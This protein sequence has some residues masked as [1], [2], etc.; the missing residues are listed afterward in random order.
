MTLAWKSMIGWRAGAGLAVV[1]ILLAKSLHPIVV[2][3]RRRSNR[4]RSGTL[5]IL[6]DGDD[7]EFE[8]VG[9]AHS[10]C[11]SGLLCHSIIAVHGLG[12]DPDRTWTHAVERTQ[13]RED[14][15]QQPSHRPGRIHLLQDLLR[16][17]FPKA[18]IL[19]FK[20]N[21]NWLM[22]APLKTIEEIG[23]SLLE[24]IK[25][26][27]RPRVV[28]RDSAVVHAD[29]NKEYGF[30]TDH[31]GLNKCAGREDKL[32]T[33]L[34]TAIDSL[35]APSLLQQ[36]DTLIC[37]KHYTLERLKIERLSEDLLSM[38]QCYINLAVVEQFG[39]DANRSMNGGPAAS[40]FSLFARQKVETP[41]RT[42][43]FDLATIFNPRKRRDGCMIE[44]RRILIRGRAGVG[45]TTLCKKMVYDFTHG[46]Q[47]ELHRSW[48]ER[49]SRLLWVPLRSLKGWSPTTYNY[50]NLFYD[51]Y[52][53]EEGDEYGLSL[54]RELARALNDPQSGT[55]LFILDGLD[56]I[57][58]ELGGD[59]KMA[60]FLK[61]LFDQPNVIITSRPSAKLP[62]GLQDLD[63]ELETI[64]FYPDQVKGYIK[65]TFTDAKTGEVDHR[66]I[67]KV[68]SFLE[69][70]WLIQGLVRIPI[71]LDALCYTWEDFNP[72]TVP[73]TMTGIYKA[74]V[75][76][77]WVKDVLRLE[78]KDH[79]G[80][81]LTASE[82]SPSSVEDCVEDEIRF[83]EGLAFTGM[84]NDVIDFTSEHRDVIFEHFKSK[85][86]LLNKTLPRLSFL[87]TSNPS[88]KKPDYHFLHLTF[89]EYFSETIV[90]AL[91]ALLKDKGQQ[92]DV[93]IYAAE[94][95][96]GQSNL[97]EAI[98]AALVGLL[99]D[100]DEG[101][102]IKS[103][104]AEALGY[105]SN[106]PEVTVVALLREESWNV[107]RD[108]AVALAGHWDLPEAI[109]AVLVALLKDKGE[110]KR[111]RCRAAQVMKG[112]LNFSEATVATLLAVIKEKDEDQT[113]R[114]YAAEALQGQ[115][116]L[117]EAAI[118][119]LVALLEDEREGLRSCAANV[120]GRQ[121]SLTE[122][123]VIMMAALLKDESEDLRSCAI[124]A[125]WNQSKLTEAAVIALAVRLENES[126]DVRHYATEVLGRQSNLPEAVVI[127]LI[128]LLEEESGIVQLVASEALVDQLNLPKAAVIA[129]TAL[130]KGENEDVRYYA[131]TA[132]GRQS[133][134]PE[135]TVFALAAL[136]RDEG[137]SIPYFSAVA[138][139]RQS[140]LPEA[141]VIALTAILKDES[142]D[143]RACA[144]SAL[145]GQPNLP[146]A[147]AVAL[148]VQLK[149]ESASARNCAAVALGR[150]SNL[151]EAAVVALVVLL[152]DESE[153]VRSRAT[154]ALGRRPNSLDGMIKAAGFLES[155]KLNETTNSSSLN[156]ELVEALY[157]NLLRLSFKEQFS[158]YID[159][160]YSSC[161]VNKPS[162]NW[163][164]SFEHSTQHEQL[165]AVVGRG[166]ELWNLRG[167]KLWD[168]TEG[169]DV[170]E[171]QQS[172][173]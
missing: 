63:L 59:S 146:E 145:G 120:L 115:S 12:A 58:H 2:K 122:G 74:I 80:E 126:E 133:N 131:A 52:F 51:E 64:G 102:D 159:D 1:V 153:I 137:E 35:R 121:L 127:T 136:L 66:T 128:T 165:L 164:A 56:E 26:K 149:D 113:I 118:V 49:F 24:E 86:L 100:N 21:S 46:T 129:L 144:A 97:P 87:R 19:S 14:I 54:A 67:G 43:Q 99:K 4:P 141:A 34:R 33:R 13:E 40:A 72:G 65:N 62:A 22:D 104:V 27:R 77:L 150:Q 60:R 108:F 154:E 10:T 167:Y 57:S 83:L 16:N 105:Q 75:Q 95:L 125:I 132:L 82:I 6:S 84:H 103:T 17:D 85:N 114:T 172:I 156:T 152:K 91:A 29:A 36:A 32:Y 169:E 166:R 112:Q 123:A 37:K 157:G 162:G 7:V 92:D 28:S 9:S 116:N 170:L 88:S 70:H 93:R 107:G 5:E 163:T 155:E 23:K 68:Q 110:D 139:G 3:I 38:D 45:K 147:A 90:T 109:M 94:A 71:Q 50:V 158:L 119:V 11:I 73:D 140:N 20:H 44:P 168:N 69:S 106:L 61:R 48:T 151:P 98:I 161:I 171:G 135:A 42:I 47:T 31:S 130:L 30:D 25:A 111:V 15:E 39:Q 89:Q 117:P 81:R 173:L 8:F 79:N 142:D 143:L 76:R 55:T 138:L 101:E 18:R 134:L 53:Y 124:E 148:V 96:G 78:K 160:G 41:D